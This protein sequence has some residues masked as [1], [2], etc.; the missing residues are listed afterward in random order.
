MMTVLVE[1]G[2]WIKKVAGYHKEA[3][4]NRPDT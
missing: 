1:G 3:N 2:M 4:Y